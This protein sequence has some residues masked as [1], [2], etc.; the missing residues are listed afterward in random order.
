MMKRI[1]SARTLGGA[2]AAMLLTLSLLW[3]CKRLDVNVRD[4]VDMPKIVPAAAWNGVLP[5]GSFRTHTP[6]RITLMH[7][8]STPAAGVNLQEHMKALQ[9]QDIQKGWGDLGAHFYI[10]PA[11]NIYQSRRI[12]LQGRIDDENKRDTAG[13][14]FIMFIGDYNTLAPSELLQEQLIALVGW[15]CQHHEIPL[16]NLRGLDEYIITDSPGRRMKEWLES[17]EFE[18]RIKEYLGIPL[19]T[20]TLTPTP[21]ETPLP[22]NPE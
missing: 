3:G 22:A 6:E 11:G 12:V 2:A 4:E 14:I 1:L 10:D 15:L 20:R 19:P 21:A 7:S 5:S 8:G 18:F 16:E 13:H 9:Q 17:P